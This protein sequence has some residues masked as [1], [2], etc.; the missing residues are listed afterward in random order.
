MVTLRHSF[1]NRSSVEVAQDLLGK[2]LVRDIDGRKE[3]YKIIETESYEGFE[4]KASHAHRGKTP[5]NAPMFAGPGTIYVYFTY[6]IHW[7]LNITCGK[8]GHPS[9]VLVRGLEGTSGPARLTKKLSIDKKLN[10]KMLGRASGLWIEEDNAA[11]GKRVRVRK[12]PRIGILSSGPYWSKRLLRF[13]L[14]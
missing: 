3:K 13:V 7:M 12:T 1:F 14:E 11:I 9:A 6:G 2:Y 4:D 10:G 5:R 8:A